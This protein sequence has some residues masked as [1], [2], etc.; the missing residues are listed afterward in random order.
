IVPR[1]DRIDAASGDWNRASLALD[2]SIDGRELDS[3]G[4]AHGIAQ[5]IVPEAEKYFLCIVWRERD[6]IDRAVDGRL[7][8]FPFIG[9]QIPVNG[10]PAARRTDCV[11]ASD[12]EGAKSITGE[13]A[14]CANL[15]LRDEATV[16]Q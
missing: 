2:W 13:S 1:D 8:S 12:G 15:M 6:G 3:G 5:G 10:V 9:I 16:L 11:V 4:W 7:N 14:H